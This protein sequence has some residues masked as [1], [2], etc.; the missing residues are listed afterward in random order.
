MK[1][2]G[3]PSVEQLLQTQQAA[4]LIAGY[5]RPLTLD[6]IR[7]VLEDLRRRAPKTGE[8]TLPDRDVLL[9]QVGSILRDWT[10]PRLVSVINATGV[11]L[12]T[13]L[14]RAPL[15][16]STMTAMEAVSRAYSNL[17]YDLSTGKRGS[18]LSHAETLLRQI[19]H[20]EAA[21]VV[22]NNAAAILLV[23]SAL[24]PPQTR[25]HRPLATG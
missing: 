25:H 13:N 10:I 1:L 19:T 22:N 17:E 8:I 5:G 6:A 20:A 12:H 15:S 9:D 4:E 11:I 18:R 3:L 14:G 21:M 23:L 7:A 16:A 2:H 24:A